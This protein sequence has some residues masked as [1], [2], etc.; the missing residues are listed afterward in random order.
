VST[1]EDRSFTDF[2]SAEQPDLLELAFLLTG[3]GGPAEE[4]LQTALAAIYGQWSRVGR[5]GTASTA[6]RRVLVAAPTGWRRWLSPPEQV[7][8]SLPELGPPV[9]EDEDEDLRRA[10]RGLDP[11]TRAAV[12][13]RC[14]EGLS[15]QATADLMGC[16][17]HT[18]DTELARGLAY[19]GPVLSG[20]PVGRTP[21]PAAGRRGTV[22]S[23]ENELGARL[24]SLVEREAPPLRDAREL[25]AAVRDRHRRPRRR[26]ALAAVVAVLFVA[27]P[28]VRSWTAQD[29]RPPAPAPAPALTPSDGIYDVFRAPTRGALARDGGGLDAVRLL[30]WAFDGYPE[31]VAPPV[32]DRH[33]VWAAD[34]ND[35]RWAL[36]AGP[37]PTAPQGRERR[38]TDRAVPGAVALAWFQGLPAGPV[39]DMRLRAIRYGVDPELPAAFMDGDSRA[40]IVVGAPEDE[41]EISRRPRL[42]ADGTLSRSFD[43]ALARDGVTVVFADTYAP[44]DLAVRYRVLRNGSWVTAA[45]DNDGVVGTLPTGLPIGRLRPPPPAA[46]G[47]AAAERALADAF[48]R[49]GLNDAQVSVTAVWAGDLEMDRGTARV[50]LLT[51]EVPSGAVY[52]TTALGYE[53]P[54][55][56]GGLATSSCGSELRPAGVQVDRQLY[57]LRCTAGD[58]PGSGPMAALVVVAPPGSTTG[59]ALDGGGGEIV[60]FPLVDGVA[61]E[62]LPPGLAS[63][64]VLDAAGAPLAQ[65]EPLAAGPLDD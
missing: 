2:V 45:P 34:V 32:A 38:T 11:R 48:A 23:P 65:G 51:L 31:S 59:R 6:V 58:R 9:Q 20:R 55:A 26:W 22:L 52:V 1:A 42:E 27:V 43:P 63:V 64:E 61:V 19:L 10:L 39:E 53:S 35:R 14:F 33:V 25:V 60:R 17:V 56:D 29:P 49:T 16:S 62:P 21:G 57:V 7:M 3:D 8:E 13:L 41:I 50:T 15:G 4:R 47:D 54:R 24:E 28:A 12:V 5:S 36:V 37:D 40:V 46:P 18:V 30:P 44:V